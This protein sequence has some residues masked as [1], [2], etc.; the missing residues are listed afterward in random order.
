MTINPF[1]G[2]PP[3]PWSALS[4]GSQQRCRPLGAKSKSLRFIACL[5]VLYEHIDI[6]IDIDIDTDIDIDIDVYVYVVCIHVYIHTYVEASGG[7]WFVGSS[8]AVRK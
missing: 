6:D 8:P 5:Q 1:K 4:F 7:F 2:P 3:E